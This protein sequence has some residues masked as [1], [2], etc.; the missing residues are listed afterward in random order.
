MIHTNKPKK[1]TVFLTHCELILQPTMLVCEVKRKPRNLEAYFCGSLFFP[2]KHLSNHSIQT[3]KNGYKGFT[4]TS[5]PDPRQRVPFKS[6]EYFLP[7]RTP[8]M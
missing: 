2:F 1:N 8:A 6:E 7:E 3:K 5:S 4:K